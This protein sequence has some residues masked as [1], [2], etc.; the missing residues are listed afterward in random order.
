MILMMNNNFS[1]YVGN[2]LKDQGLPEDFLMD[3]LK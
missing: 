2:A 1:V 3:L